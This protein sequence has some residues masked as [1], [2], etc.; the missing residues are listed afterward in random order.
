MKRY[1]LLIIIITFAAFSSVTQGQPTLT[2]KMDNPR[3]LRQSDKQWFMFD[4]YLKASATGTYL[5]SSQLAFNVISSSNYNTGSIY[6][7]FSGGIL[8][9][10]Y[11]THDDYVVNSALWNGNRFAMQVT[12][13]TQNNTYDPAVACAA[14]TTSF[15]KIITIGVEIST[16]TGVGAICGI[17]W[18]SGS[19]TASGDL[20]TYASAGTAL[21]AHV[22]YADPNAFFSN[23]FANVYL[24]R[25]Y[26]NAYGWS[27]YGGGT[28]GSSYIDWTTAV[29]TSVWDTLN[30]TPASISSAGSKTLALRIH[31]NARLAIASTADLTCTGTTEI[32]KASG[33]VI[34][35]DASGRG[36]F[37]DNGTITY[38]GS[39]SAQVWA[40]FPQDMWKYY[41][42]PLT[43]A[44]M[45]SVRAFSMI[46][47]KYYQEPTDHWKYIWAFNFTPDT[48]LL[49]MQ[50]VGYAMYSASDNP[51]GTSPQTIKPSGQLNTG[52]LS[53]D[54]PR[55]SWSGGGYNGYNLIG[56]PYPSSIDLQN[57]GWSC[58]PEIDPTA[59]YYYG[60]AADVGKYKTYNWSTGTGSGTRYPAP[61]EGFLI[62]MS[63]GSSASVTVVN[64]ARTVQ[65]GIPTKD[66]PYST[67]Y[68]ILTANA[69]GIEDDA[70]I[71]FNQG[72]TIGF[73]SQLDAYKL[74]GGNLTPNLY[75]RMDTIMAVNELPW[76]GI[77]QVIPMGF[78][79]GVSGTYTI[80]ARNLQSF[81]LGTT[82]YLEDRKV[83]NMQNLMQYPVYSFDYASGED[84]N[85]FV[86]HFTN[87][88]FGISIEGLAGM[89]IYSFENYLYVKNLVKGATK[90]T[91]QIFDLL[92]R[93]VFQANLKDLEL[94]KFLPGVNEG[95]YMVRVVTAD[96]SYSQKV[97]LK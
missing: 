7:S 47:M 85:R 12:A 19:M 64:T 33:L 21:P 62:H 82:I 55:S 11:L 69:N 26:S 60:A 86:L 3:V 84:V 66:A 61:Q 20:Q 40:Y 72:A 89:Q 39:G 92:G 74:F 88:Y 25:V 38:N 80:T 76:T 57:S 36:Q 91:V 83:A 42:I 63:S 2:F 75:S 31:S 32:N 22:D 37:I 95:Y 52:V 54:C 17:T 56:N 24:A 71:H 77:N 94:N 81:R 5:Y 41:C 10:T 73:D 50:M 30:G 35:A 6:T 4:V 67:D 59:Y 97:Y 87:P 34:K 14:I 27:Q 29:N 45:T 43:Q 65:N 23:D 58:P 13:N 44:S 46:Y 8:S 51:Y 68:L 48:N 49:T 93:N 28:N 9:G 16:P 70:H 15:Q 1:T 18:R 78:R 79:C 96:N 53:I 90:G